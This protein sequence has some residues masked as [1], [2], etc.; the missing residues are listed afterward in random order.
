[1][2]SDSTGFLYPFLGGTAVDETALVDDLAAS[3]AGK[4]SVSEAL[5]SSTFDATRTHLDG[6]AGALAAAARSG[7]R[8][9]VAGNGGSA[10]DAAGFA[11]LL[12]EPPWGEPMGSLCLAEDPTILTA[13][14]NDVG[15]SLIFARQVGAHGKPGDVLV[16]ISTSGRSENILVALATARRG[17]LVTIAITG[18]GGDD[19]LAD[20]SCD[21][22][23]VVRSDSVHR[24]QETQEAVLFE[25]WARAQ[26]RL[27]EVSS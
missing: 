12:R 16:V 1:M 5:R 14:A 8:A 11:A 25:V 6:A 10:A 19:L 27:E 21:H 24:I 18:E 9:L 2:S 23:I 20:G 3:A 7:G 15:T 13:L 22:V 4:R 26:R 17:G